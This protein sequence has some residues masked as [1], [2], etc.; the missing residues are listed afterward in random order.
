MPVADQREARRAANCRW[1]SF[2][3]KVFVFSCVLA[4]SWSGSRSPTNGR[5]G[6]ALSRAAFRFEALEEFAFGLL[7]GQRGLG[8]GLQLRE[9]I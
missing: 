5:R 2:H 3:R 8:I 4:L 1:F 6:P 7:H 9:A